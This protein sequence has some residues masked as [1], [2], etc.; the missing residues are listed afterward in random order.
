MIEAQTGTQPGPTSP[1]R[2]RGRAWGQRLQLAMV[3]A[4]TAPR[5]TATRC[6]RCSG[7]GHSAV[8]RHSRPGLPPDGA[9]AR[10]PNRGGRWAKAIRAAPVTARSRCRRPRL[11]RFNTL[12]GSPCESHICLDGTPPSVSMSLTPLVRS[13]IP[14]GGRPTKLT[15]TRRMVTCSVM[16]VT[17][18]ASG[19]GE[20]LRIDDRLRSGGGRR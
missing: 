8:S 7:A 13:R 11:E 4:Q 19:S 1:F 15:S 12:L 3:P 18:G 14:I 9:S 5:T 20:I 17:L 10:R 6:A 16:A 2:R